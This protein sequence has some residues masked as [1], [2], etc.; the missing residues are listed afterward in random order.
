MELW[1][2]VCLAGLALI[3][4]AVFLLLIGKKGKSAGRIIG[5]VLTAILS[6]AALI[7]CLS[8]WI[9]IE[10][11]DSPI[12]QNPTTMTTVPPA[13]QAPTQATEIQPTSPPTEPTEETIPEMPD[14]MH[15]RNLQ[16]EKVPEFTT[17]PDLTRYLLSQLL[18]G[19]FKMDFYMI[20]S[21][22]PS[23][24]EGYSMVTN[25]LRSANT[26]YLF[27]AYDIYTLHVEDTGREGWMLAH[28]EIR[29]ENPE[30]DRKAQ[31]KAW[32]FVKENPVPQ[33]GFQ[34]KIQEMEYARKIQIYLVKRLS[35]DPIGYSLDTMMNASQYDNKQEA[36]TA[37]VG[38][39]R[40]TVCAGFARAFALIAQYAG[41]DC[42]YVNG[43]EDPETWETHAWN[44]I[45]PCDGSDPVIVDVT[46]DN[47]DTID[48][49]TG[50]ETLIF[51]NFYGLVQGNSEHHMYDDTWL[52]LQSMHK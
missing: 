49:D 21:I 1:L 9:L 46:W 22:S 30:Y 38:E 7:Y 29:P 17:A 16:Y 11:D 45:Y 43:N 34:N 10:R 12:E 52:F 32:E 6:A 27:G 33:G 15:V 23:D 41:I 42:A 44:V 28:L 51:P 14:I 5:A 8:A 3:G 26:Y 37:L 13:T 31:E 20:E 2:A 50:E 18:K 48:P 35:Y 39:D 36:Y 19:S 4:L 47:Q 40:L 24:G 25:C